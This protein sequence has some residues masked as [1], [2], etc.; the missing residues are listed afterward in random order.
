MN[1][2][3]V[4]CFIL[5]TAFIS[6]V[7][8]ILVIFFLRS[9]DKSRKTFFFFPPPD[10]LPHTE[11]NNINTY[12]SGVRAGTLLKLIFQNVFPLLVQLRGRPPIRCSPSHNQSLC[13]AG[14]GQEGGGRCGWGRESWGQPRGRVT[15]EQSIRGGSSQ[16][17]PHLPG[18][19]TAQSL[20]DCLGSSA[21]VFQGESHLKQKRSVPREEKS[22]ETWTQALLSAARGISSESGDHDPDPLPSAPR[23]SHLGSLGPAPGVRCGPGV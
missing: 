23:G 5:L 9:Q 13:G 2:P 7:S 20:R 14:S 19:L 21:G 8:L 11:V 4:F 12:V 18:L 6:P 15:L 1:T 16:F 17:L 3:E 22:P 10:K